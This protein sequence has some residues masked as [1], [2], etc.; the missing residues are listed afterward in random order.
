MIRFTIITCTFNAA[1]TLSRTLESVRRQ[2]YPRVQ[3]VIVDGCSSDGGTLALIEQYRAEN[4]AAGSTHVVDVTV[5]KDKGLYDAMNKGMQQATGDYLVFLNAG[6]VLPSEHTLELLADKA[7]D[8]ETLP[9]VLYGDTHIVNDEG[10]FLRRR[11]LTPPPHLSWKSFKHGMLVCHQAFY[12]L[13]SIAQETPYNLTYRYSAD[14]DWCIRVMKKAEERHLELRNVDAVLV[15]YLDEGMTTANHK[16]SLKERFRVMCAH[17][18]C[19]STL[20]MHLWFVLRA[21]LKK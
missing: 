7:G 14:V 19:F 10:Q 1:Q 8:A 6:D 3:H 5:E 16:A 4:K 12:V 18:G 15:N 17:Y 11:R 9:A 2:T 13:T 21:I 20:C